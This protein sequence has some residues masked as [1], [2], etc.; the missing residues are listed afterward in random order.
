MENKYGKYYYT[1]QAFKNTNLK[2]ANIMTTD[3]LWEMAPS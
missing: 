1:F 3:G 2:Q